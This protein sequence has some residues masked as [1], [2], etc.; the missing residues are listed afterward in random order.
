MEKKN[1]LFYFKLIKCELFVCVCVLVPA[2]D[3]N[4]SNK[5]SSTNTDNANTSGDDSNAPTSAG[6]TT[7]NSSEG[8]VKFVEA[9]L[10]KVNAWKVSAFQF[11]KNSLSFQHFHSLLLDFG[12]YPFSL[13]NNGTEKKSIVIEYFI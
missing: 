3:S 13:K 5:A 7:T 9:P 4:T 10:P 8:A 11:L 2:G 6:N 12:F 1:L